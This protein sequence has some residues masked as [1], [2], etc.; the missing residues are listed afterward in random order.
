M[1]HHQHRD[2]STFKNACLL[3]AK[4]TIKLNRDRSKMS[5]IFES[6]FGPEYT[7]SFNDGASGA[8]DASNTV[9]ILVVSL[10]SLST[11]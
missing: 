6:K 9:R 10:S 8:Q 1:L 2:L 4:I 3:S 7:Q 5:N 11:G